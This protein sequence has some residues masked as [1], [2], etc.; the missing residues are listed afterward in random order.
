MKLKRIYFGVLILLVV[1]GLAL[2]VL[3]RTRDFPSATHQAEDAYFSPRVCYDLELVDPVHPDLAGRMLPMWLSFDHQGF[4]DEYQLSLQTEVCLERVCKL[5]KVT[6]VWG[7]LGNYSRLELPRGDPL[8]KKNHD[9]FDSGDYERLDE[10]LKDKQSILGTYPVDFF[11]RPPVKSYTDEVDGITS[12]TPQ[13]V[14]DAVVSEAA[15]TSWVLWHWVNGDVADELRARTLPYCDPEYLLHCLQLNDPR[16][17]EFAFQYILENDICDPQIREA[18]FQ[19]LEKSGKANCNL[20]L[21]VLTRNPPDA[22]ELHRLL[23]ERIGVNEGSGQ[24]ILNYFEELPVAD[25]ALWE[26]LAQH[27]DRLSVYYDIHAV[28]SLLEKRAA[29]TE[30]TRLHAEKLLDHENRFIVRRARDFLEN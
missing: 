29:K 3:L 16:F 15:Y 30:T 27:L 7:A 8:T 19:T 20:A 18:C 22:D 21:R 10:I 9:P 5:L 26:Q 24:L 13:T 17:V 6:L 11:V 1:T 4:P 14:L 23:I 25:Q 12:A 28:L 2:S